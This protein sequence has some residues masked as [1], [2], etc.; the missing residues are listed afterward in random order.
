VIVKF[1]KST[2]SQDQ[3]TTQSADKPE[4]ISLRELQKEEEPHDRKELEKSRP[5][6]AGEQS[7]AGSIPNPEH[8]TTKTTLER[9]K[10]M[11]FQT[12][13]KKQEHT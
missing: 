12:K 6:V 13:E 11:G 5:H 4:I 3:R 8:I 1:K 7:A 2:P 10:K 9:A